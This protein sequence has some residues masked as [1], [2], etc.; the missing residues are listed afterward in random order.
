MGNQMILLSILILCSICVYGESAVLSNDTESVTESIETEFDLKAYRE[1]LENQTKGFEK[2]VK[3]FMKNTIKRLLPS[4]MNYNDDSPLSTKCMGSF[5]KYISGLTSAKVWAIRM[6]DATSKIPS[7]I[8]DGTL[9]A[10]GDFDQ[11]LA[12]ELPTRK[13][14]IEFRGQYCAIEAR[15]FLPPTPKNF[16]LARQEFAKPMDTIAEEVK[17]AGMAFYFLKF[18]FGVCIPSTCTL[19]EMQGVA[20]QMSDRLQFDIQIPECYAKEEV[21]FKPIHIAVICILSLLLIACIAGSVIE[22]KSMN[23]STSNNKISTGQQILKCF[24]F[25]SNYRRLISASKGSEELKVL[26]GLRALSI[27]YVILGHTY[28]WINFQLLRTPNQTAIW[29]KRLDFGPILNGWMSVEPFF[30]LSGLLTSYAGMNILPKTKGRINIPFY[31]LRRYL[32]LTPGLLL[33]MG[34]TFFLPLI[35]SGPFW[36]ERVDPEIE[37][38][39]KYWWRSILYISNWFG[40]SNICVHPTWYLSADFQLHIIT[41]VFLILLYRKPKLGLTLIAAFVVACTVMVAALT[42]H[43]EL[44]PLILISSGNDKQIEKT[45]DDVHMNTFTHAGPYYVGIVTGY[46]IYKYKHIKMSKT[47]VTCGW[48]LSVIVSLTSLYGAHRWNIGYPHGPL[49]TAIYA[50]L[51]RTTYSVGVAW[52]AFACVTGYGGLVNRFLS[53]TIFAP[54]SRLTYMIYL[55]HSLVIWVRVGSRRERMFQSHYNCVYEFFGNIITSLLVTI[56]FYLLLE[57]PVSNL[58]RLV[59]SKSKGTEDKNSRPNGHLQ[60]NMT[61]SQ[62]N[63]VDIEARELGVPVEL[64]SVKHIE[65]G[66]TNLGF[67][68]DVNSPKNQ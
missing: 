20:K 24:S 8:F 43:W 16:S 40:M 27:A 54:V 12:V 15:P 39:T 30:I 37:S 36:Y 33:V 7:G 28:V 19:E 11:C 34:L 29:F 65:N 59:F 22:Y 26:H 32:R 62:R 4:L 52:V 46:L 44:P 21:Y 68:V 9:N 2:A 1:R 51:H 45:V 55:L 3:T 48:F 56:P 42:Y 25:I 6:L 35:S 23:M 14:T 38:C 58:E 60:T 66:S 47:F 18:R 13:G 57:A 5:M 49:L 61:H 41:V 50:G 67:N 53:S 17:I 63:M 10:F 31:I 64:M